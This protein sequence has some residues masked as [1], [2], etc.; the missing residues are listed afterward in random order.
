M[1]RESKRKASKTT[2][3][4]RN[5]APP[6]NHKIIKFQINN[7]I[8]IM[9]IIIITIIRILIMINN[10]NNNDNSNNDNNNNYNN[11]DNT[12]DNDNKYNKYIYIHIYIYISQL[13]PVPTTAPWY[14]VGAPRASAAGARSRRPR[15]CPSPWSPCL[16]WLPQPRGHSPATKNDAHANTGQQNVTPPPQKKRAELDK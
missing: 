13:N 3:T 2:H 5:S 16:R 11:N 7:I 8:I 14:P 15:R 4:H 6:T 1:Q 9:M 10:Y 12:N